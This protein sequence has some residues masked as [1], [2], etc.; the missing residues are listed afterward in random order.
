METTQQNPNQTRT[1][2]RRGP[3]TVSEYT[4]YLHSYDGRYIQCKD[5][6]HQWDLTEDY[7][8][9]SDG[10]VTRKMTCMRCDTVRTEIFAI[11]NKA[12]LVK[13]STSYAYP[14]GYQI[15]GLPQTRGLSELLRFEAIRRSGIVR[16]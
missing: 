16:G 3:M 4:E 6:R 7:T 11:V 5:M 1:K 8:L 2:Q 9:R 15:H 13:Q 10:W 14:E 12:R